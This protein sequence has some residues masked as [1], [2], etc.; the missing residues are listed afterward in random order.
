MFITQETCLPMCLKSFHPFAIKNCINLI[1]WL[2]LGRNFSS[3]SFSYQNFSKFSFF[4]LVFKRSVRPNERPHDPRNGKLLILNLSRITDRDHNKC[5]SWLLNFET[6]TDFL[7]SSNSLKMISF[8]LAQPFGVISVIAVGLIKEKSSLMFQVQSRMKLNLIIQKHF[9][10]QQKV[11]E[12]LYRLE[13]KHFQSS[14]LA[15]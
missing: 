15:R 8:S 2:F 13:G 9:I 12:E 5:L 11:S 6:E 14:S 1:L 3:F 7:S 10:N 4:F